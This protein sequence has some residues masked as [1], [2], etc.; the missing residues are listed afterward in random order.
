MAIWR[1]EIDIA[2]RVEQIRHRCG[3]L[4]GPLHHGSGID[5]G[6]VTFAGSST[7][8]RHSQS[9]LLD[10]LDFLQAHDLFLAND[11]TESCGGAL[12]AL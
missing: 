11:I 12:G 6:K 1:R 5:Q 2:S 3:W 7:F 8:F 10:Q 9:R 4:H